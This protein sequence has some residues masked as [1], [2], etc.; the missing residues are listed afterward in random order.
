MD[1]DGRRSEVWKICVKQSQC[2]NDLS[3]THKLKFV[4]SIL[5][6]LNSDI[7]MLSDIP[8]KIILKINICS[9]ISTMK[10]VP[11]IEKLQEDLKPV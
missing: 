10:F 6:F 3:G 11:T 4:D 9:A 7:F 1:Y 5:V 8:I 2:I